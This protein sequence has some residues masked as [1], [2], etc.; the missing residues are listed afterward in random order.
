M[1]SLRHLRDL[2][3][4]ELTKRLAYD[5]T[6]GWRKYLGKLKGDYSVSL[7]SRK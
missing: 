3:V 4:D 6:W 5:H 2:Q 1:F 7:L